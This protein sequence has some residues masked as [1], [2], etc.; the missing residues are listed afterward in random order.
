[1]DE[2]KKESEK[3]P[4]GYSVEHSNFIRVRGSIRGRGVTGPDSF[5][6][7]CDSFG[8]KVTKS[9]PIYGGVQS[10]SISFYEDELEGF[11]GLLEKLKRA[12]ESED[13]KRLKDDQ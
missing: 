7:F 2:D 10:S 9:T 4:F 5:D 1:M 11:I 12:I 3:D 13:K 8:I 6:L